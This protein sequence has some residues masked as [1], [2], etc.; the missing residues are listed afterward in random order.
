MPATRTELFEKA[1]KGTADVIFLDVEVVTRSIKL[2]LHN[3]A[4][5]EIAETSTYL[6]HSRNL[7]YLEDSVAP[8]EKD[9]ARRNVVQALDRQ[10]T[11][12]Q[13]I[14]TGKHMNNNNTATTAK[15]IQALN[16]IDW[17]KK[18][19][20][21]RVNGLDTQF[22]YRDIVDIIEKTG[23]RLDL[24]ML[25]KIG[26]RH[27]I[28]ACDMLVS[29]VEMAKGRKKRIGFEIIIET[30]LGMSN[31]NEIAA[32][33]TRNESLH[34]GVADYAASTKARTTGIGGPN[35]E[36]GVLTDKDGDKPR[37]YHWQDLWGYPIARMVVAA[38]ANGLR[39]VDGPFGDFSD[40]D[41]YNAQARR[42]ATLGCEGKWAIHPTQI[43]MANEVYSPSEKEVTQAKRIL[44]AMDDAAKKGM[45]AVSL[46]GKLIDIASIKQ[47]EVLPVS[48]KGRV[49]S[50]R[51]SPP[52]AL[53][54]SFK[55]DLTRWADSAGP[56]SL[57]DISPSLR[58]L[59]GEGGADRRQ[60]RRL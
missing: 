21:V 28:Y 29:Q 43:K 27:D 58:G 16:E 37:E 54:L 15:V 22:L 19:M 31:V 12:I 3:I 6:A 7:S 34:F 46:D 44:E 18:T 52:R 10:P 57:E 50:E 26:N 1:S 35:S 14:L 45:G 9:A 24:M 25:P 41:G 53:P 23:E 47:A 59:R 8:D 38:H 17:G 11:N 55:T 2:L 5:L 49:A 13:H 4:Y 42:A 51:C 39:P 36:Y 60:L 20:S 30:A 56:P 33:S 40:L 32:A 48:S